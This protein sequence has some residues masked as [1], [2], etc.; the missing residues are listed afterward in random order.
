MSQLSKIIA[1]ILVIIALLIGGFAMY[2]LSRPAP[3]PTP[4]ATSTQVETP[5]AP[6]PVATFAVTVAKENIPAGSLLNA[7]L[8]KIAQWPVQ[9]E[10]SYA[11]IDL[12]ANE[13]NRSDI[14][15][16]EPILSTHLM[17]GLASYLEN[18]ERAVNVPISSL[19][20]QADSIRPGDYIDVFFTLNRQSGEV[21]SSQSRLLLAK[22]RV[23][24]VGNQ[25]LDGPIN[26]EKKEPSVKDN[27]SI[28][29]AVPVKEINSLLLAKGEGKL[30]LV[31]RAPKDDMT[32]NV[33]LF[34]ER[35]P[36]LAGK[37]TL[38]QQE[39]DQLNH[40]ENKAFAGDSLIQFGGPI[41]ES[42]SSLDMPTDKEK[43]RSQ[44]RPQRTVEI[45]RG[46]NK[47]IEV[48]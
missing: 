4:V 8:L 26:T 36:V 48:F 9:P 42:P 16:G 1:S 35:V 17:K 23:L 44:I 21:L 3:A 28:I 25:S 5:P 24:A 6:K 29:L 14:A 27:A 34:N 40:P 32:P 2:L 11:S 12:L 18:G 13:Y 43:P 15:A 22:V 39:K 38:S 7:E 37:T 45:I 31:L 20:T 33:A 46:R 19:A 41:A 10:N 47:N 30:Q